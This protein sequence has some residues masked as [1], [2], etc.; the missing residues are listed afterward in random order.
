RSAYAVSHS[1]GRLLY[2]Q[3]DG[4]KL[5]EEKWFADRRPAGRFQ[6]ATRRL[7]LRVSR[8]EYEAPRHQRA[9]TRQLAEERV[10]RHIGHPQI[11]QDAVVPALGNQCQGLT[12]AADGVY[13]MTQRA[14]VRR[15]R[16]ANGGLVVDHQQVARKGWYRLRTGVARF[17]GT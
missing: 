10:P 3:Q 13:R 5:V 15:H 11:Q 17:D 14:E 12:A 9:T 7:A 8:K 2:C 1:L 4:G 16:A 6:E